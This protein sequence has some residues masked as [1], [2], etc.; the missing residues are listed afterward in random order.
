[1]PVGHREEFVLVARATRYIGHQSPRITAIGGGGGGVNDG[2]F[3]SKPALDHTL[4][5]LRSQ[6]KKNIRVNQ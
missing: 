1:M 3:K 5:E 2:P 4:C 6:E